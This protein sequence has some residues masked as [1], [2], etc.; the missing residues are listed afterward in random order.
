MTTM[1]ESG[2]YHIW[3]LVWTERSGALLLECN[4]GDDAMLSA[5]LVQMAEWARKRAASA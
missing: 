5:R 4:M 2:V 1:S 3:A